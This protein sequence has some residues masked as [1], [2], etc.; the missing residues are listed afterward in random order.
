M[1]GTSKNRQTKRLTFRV[2]GIQSLMMR[3]ILPIAAIVICFISLSFAQP[4][5]KKPQY[6]STA[7][8]TK[9]VKENHQKKTVERSKVKEQPKR[10]SKSRYQ[11]KQETPRHESKP[12]KTDRFVDKDNNGVNDLT[13]KRKKKELPESFLKVIGKLLKKIKPKE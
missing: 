9:V 12:K 11:A 2:Q 7:K 4:N 6:K 8:Q 13:E 3:R 10:E 1:N 5:R